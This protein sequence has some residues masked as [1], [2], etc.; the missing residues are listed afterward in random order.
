[1]L[2]HQLKVPRRSVGRPRLRPWGRVLLAAASRVVPRERWTSFLVTPQTSLAPR[3]R[4]EE[5]DVSPAE[6]AGKAAARYRGPRPDP[7][8]GQGEPEIGLPQDPRGACQARDPRVGHDDQDD[9]SSRGTRSGSSPLRAELEPV[10]SST[11]GGRARLRLL[12]RG[13]GLAEDPLPT[14]YV[15]RGCCLLRASPPPAVAMA[16]WRCNA[17]RPGLHRTP[18]ST[19]RPQA[20]LRLAPPGRPAHQAPRGVDGLGD[21]SP[22]DRRLGSI[23]CPSAQPATPI[24]CLCPAGPRPARDPD[25]SVRD[26][27]KSAFR[28]HSLAPGLGTPQPEP[29]VTITPCGGC[30]SPCLSRS[31]AF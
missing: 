13:D 26:P 8:Y 30:G 2:R 9:P 6:S 22:Q 29:V 1:M 10:P 14:S 17:L 19:G 21:R 24:P 25:S 11:G 18:T 3:A 23:S 27:S 4:P 16:G 15:E 20:Q 12:H 28:F 31:S 5:V 7:S